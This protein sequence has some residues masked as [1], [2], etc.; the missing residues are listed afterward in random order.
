MKYE[1][2]KAE[3]IRL[4]FIYESNRHPE[5]ESFKLIQD[6]ITYHACISYPFIETWNHEGATGTRM[7]YS[8]LQDIEEVFNKLI[9]KELR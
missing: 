3:L 9:E 5:G 7:W 6:G 4:G 8:E 1:D 2:A